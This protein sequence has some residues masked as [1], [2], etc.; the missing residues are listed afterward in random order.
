LGGYI[1]GNFGSGA[2]CRMMRHTIDGGHMDAALDQH[3]ERAR[4]WAFITSVDAF[5]NTIC[6]DELKGRMEW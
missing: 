6:A 4:H 2:V 1:G 5:V 3:N